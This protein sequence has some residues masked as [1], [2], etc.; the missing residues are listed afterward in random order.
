MPW[1]KVLAGMDCSPKIRK[2][3]R[4]TLLCLLAVC[5]GASPAMAGK[6]KPKGGG[7]EAGKHGAKEG[8]HGGEGKEEG[9][10]P[11]PNV[12]VAKIPSMYRPQL[13]HAATT[14]HGGGGY[15]VRMVAKLRIPSLFE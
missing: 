14:L 10:P 9:P 3:M 7:G 8:G 11:N 12:T 6:K 15:P 13:P 1:K 4:F 5:L 2:L